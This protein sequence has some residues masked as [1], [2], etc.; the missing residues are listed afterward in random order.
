MQ[1]QG[2]HGRRWKPRRLVA[3][4][5]VGA[6]LATGMTPAAA[7]IVSMGTGADGLTRNITVFHNIDFVAAFNWPVGTEL[8]VSVV[9]NGVTIGSA[10]G[11]AVDT[12]EGGG[13]EVNHGPAGA[14]QPGDC[15]EGWTPDIQPGDRIV[16]TGGGSTDEVVVDD[17]RFTSG[18]VQT[19]V[20]G[21]TETRVSGIAK[22]ADGSPIPVAELDSAEFLDTSALRGAPDETVETNPGAGDG[23]FT[24]IF[25]T[26]Y[27]NNFAGAFGRNTDGLSEAEI[28]QRLLGDGYGIGFGHV[29]PLPPE[30]ML[31]DGIADVPGPALG[32]EGSPAAVDAVSSVTPGV[33]NA[34]TVAAGGPTT[35]S[36]GGMSFNATAVQARVTDS[37]ATPATIAADAAMSTSA[38]DT[39]QTWTAAFP[40][41]GV[42]ALADGP[43]TVSMAKN[44][45]ATPEPRTQT[46]IK[47]TVAPVAPTATPG[48]GEYKG[49]QAVT[50]SGQAGET[51]HYTVDGT[52]PTVTSPVATG[53]IQVTSPQTIKAV[54]VD[55][56][57]N[58]GPVAS[59]AYTFAPGVVSTDSGATGEVD[60]GGR[61]FS[62]GTTASPSNALLTSLT[63]P[64]GGA[65]TIAER[66]RS[67]SGGPAGYSLLGQE[68]A[69]TAP[70]GTA[71]A[72]MR[73]SFRLDGS[74]LPAGEPGRAVSVQRNGVTVPA[75]TS[76]DGS[77]APDPCLASRVVEGDDTVI[78]VL[79]SAASTWTFATPAFASIGAACTGIT[80]ESFSDVGGNTHAAAISC[81]SGLK[82]TGGI[83]GGQYGPSRNVTRAQMASFVHRLMTNAGYALPAGDP[84]RFT[85]DGGLHETAISSLAQAGVINGL[86]AQAY[87]PN[88]PVSRA[89]MAALLDRSYRLLGG[90]RTASTTEAFGDDN[91]S[92]HQA[93]IN[94]LAALGVT[95][96]LTPTSYGPNA[97]V[98]RDQM[99]SFLTRLV[100]RLKAEGTTS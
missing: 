71:S 34:A 59:F 97:D 9:R 75:C 5:A 36:L 48:A 44:G 76:S 46:I 87:G 8:T 47:D 17:I 42:A 31:V 7:T 86:T 32:C 14:P 64:Q 92:V 96:G 10:T 70:A 51:V 90:V 84:N 81:L 83:G 40:M 89:Q 22:R 11:P 82:I 23:A 61:I 15:W 63:S 12:P 74:Q 49:P 26:P 25:R 21:V 91:D 35:L 30:A 60:P 93:S 80:G 100:S 18:P 95:T 3:L 62:L 72:P 33:I 2:T 19:S 52:D 13:I 50:L 6:L 53:Q 20:G 66:A 58:A 77:A 85:D 27:N 16:V 43:L 38:A 57:G 54:A 41:A 39:P 67:G 73:I 29:A 68:V 79:T 98:K 78:T 45:S 55:A 37:A 28:S 65:V 1:Q 24:S 56:A 69:I 94:N 88:Q 99:A 4:G